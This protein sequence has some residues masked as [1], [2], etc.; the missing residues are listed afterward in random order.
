MRNH[1]I[2]AARGRS[3]VSRRD[4]VVVKR[5]RRPDVRNDVE[6]DA[7]RH[8]SRFDAPVPRFVEATADELVLEDVANVGD[9]EAAFVRFLHDRGH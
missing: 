7:Y 4:G 8:L 2:I 5:Y 3:V 1:E 6:C 9:F